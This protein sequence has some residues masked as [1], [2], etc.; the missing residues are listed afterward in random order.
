MTELKT[1]K[2]FVENNYPVEGPM[3]YDEGQR[4]GR[5]RLSTELRQEAIRWVK[6]LKIIS[7]QDRKESHGYDRIM[8]EGKIVWIIHFFN[9]TEAD[10]ATEINFKNGSKIVIDKT[11]E[12][13]RGYDEGDLK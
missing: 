9:L 6:E 3:S 2:D 12:K 7:E 5:C 11:K 13:L 1:L 10:I 8:T 4:D